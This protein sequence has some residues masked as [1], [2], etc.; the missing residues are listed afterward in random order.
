MYLRLLTIPG[1]CCLEWAYIVGSK[2]KGWIPKRMFQENK[3]RQIFR[4]A[5]ISYP[6][7]RIRTCAYQG[8]KNVRFSEILACFIFLKH[9]FPDSPFCLIIDDI[10]L[11]KAIFNASKIRGAHENF[12]EKCFHG[13]KFKWREALLFSWLAEK[14]SQYSFKT[15]ELNVNAPSKLK[16]SSEKPY[17]FFISKK[18]WM[19]K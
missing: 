7:I 11:K 4:K 2:S 3:A 15:D 17:V 1:R 6:L 18:Y 14:N 19:D 5:N 10:Y 13:R 9:P 16:N 8:V 12:D